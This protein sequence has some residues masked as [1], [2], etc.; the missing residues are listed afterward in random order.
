M[1]FIVEPSSWSLKLSYSSNLRYL[2]SFSALFFINYFFSHLR[3]CTSLLLSLLLL[4]LLFALQ[5]IHTEAF[6]G[7]PKVKS[8]AA[9][10]RSYVHI[11]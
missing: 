4:L 10:C 2:F 9:A 5:V 11:P 6:I 1:S 3:A 8:A 7:Q